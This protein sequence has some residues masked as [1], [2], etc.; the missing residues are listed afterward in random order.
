MDQIEQYR[1]LINQE[2]ERLQPG[3]DN[4]IYQ[5]IQYM[6]SMGGKR[7]RP[8]LVLMGY[9][10]FKPDVEKILRPAIAVELFHNFTLMHDDIMDKAPL[11]RGKPTVHEKWNSNVAILSGD[12][13][14]VK[15][16]QLLQEV[17]PEILPKVLELFNRC[18]IEVCEGQQLDMEFETRDMVSE[19]EYLEMIRLKTAVL[20]GFSLNLGALLAGASSDNCKLL[21]DFGE[22]VGVG[23][24]L[25]DDILDV[26]G[27]QEKFGKRVGGDIISHKKT[28]L[29]IKAQEKLKHKPLLD[30]YLTS[31]AFTDEDRVREV[32]RLY[33]EIGVKEIAESTMNTTFQEAFENLTEV[34]TEAKN[35][36]LLVTFTN[37]LISRDH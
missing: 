36:D 21:K 13:M 34:Q 23:F 33:D 18:A 32:T 16:Y 24:Q 29:L 12:V 9:A 35:K 15:V 7:L 4:E 2:I 37:H 8:L 3:S 31:N 25:K 26:Y 22:N 28:F 17:N 5:P 11:R 19:A 14:F 30:N 1:Q 10:M 27:D 20:I 6:L